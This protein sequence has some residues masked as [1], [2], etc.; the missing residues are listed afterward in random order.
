MG[1][2][3]PKTT[4]ATT[5]PQ[6]LNGTMK[7]KSITMTLTPMTVSTQMKVGKKKSIAPPS[8]MSHVQ[9]FRMK[10]TIDGPAAVTSPTT[11]AWK[12]SRSEDQTP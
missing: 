10:R 7:M 6:N 12:A 4:R 8:I 1:A 2:T 5:T 11:A 3:A 9:W